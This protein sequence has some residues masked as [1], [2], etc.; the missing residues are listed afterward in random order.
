M[1]G[2]GAA[3]GLAPRKALGYAAVAYLGI[4]L[5]V[6][7]I[8]LSRIVILTWPRLLFWWVGFKIGVVPPPD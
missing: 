1:A 6:Q 3:L 4:G 5:V 8:T 7:L 2:V